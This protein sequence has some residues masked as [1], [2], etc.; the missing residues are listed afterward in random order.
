MGGGAVSTIPATLVY[1]KQEGR[2]L[3]LEKAGG[4][5]NGLGGKFEPGEGPLACARREV[6]EES[7]LRV[8][9]LAWHGFIDFPG[10]DGER[11]WLVWIYSCR[12]FT[13]D[14]RASDEGRLHWIP[15]EEVANLNL[16]DGDRHFLPWIS[17][18]TFFHAT[19]LYE[20]GRY[21]RHTVQ[22][23]G[24]RAMEMLP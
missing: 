6:F 1:V 18:G 17:Q 22:F 14:L 13:G 2:T 19:F 11:D 16:W 10:F 9:T 20:Q 21:L 15:D 12:D 24:P 8:G 4:R 5:W 23:P 7:G 3:M